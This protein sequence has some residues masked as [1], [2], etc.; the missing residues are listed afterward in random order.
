[1][2]VGSDLQPHQAA[3]RPRNSEA[4][5]QPS[6][7]IYPAFKRTLDVLLAFMIGVFALPVIVVMAIA[8]KLTSRGPFIY[9]QR[10]SGFDGRE[11]VIYKVRTMYEDA[12]RRG[13]AQWATEHD[14]RITPI[15]R[16][17]RKS[18][19]DEF[20]QLWNILR[21]EMSLVGPRP[22]RPEFIVQLE[23][24]IPHYRERLNVRPGVTGLAQIQLP[25]DVDLISVR[26]KLSCDLFYI[27]RLG[28]WMDF[29]ILLVTGLSL[30]GLRYPTGCRIFRVPDQDDI[31]SKCKVVKVLRRQTA[32][33]HEKPSQFESTAAHMDPVY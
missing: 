2:Y 23:V 21:G 26:R 7:P 20:P 28:A 10:R 27:E 11:F 16:F 14:P 3:A 30:V 12:E 1:M 6:N 5:M 9:T 31:E 25:A 8:V 17:L 15:G 13:G 18:H 33:D 19:L 22:E 24:A 29:K 4:T 32:Y